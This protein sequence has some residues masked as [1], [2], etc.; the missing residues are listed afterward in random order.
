[1]DFQDFGLSLLTAH[2]SGEIDFGGKLHFKTCTSGE[3]DDRGLNWCLH[4]LEMWVYSACVMLRGQ[5]CKDACKLHQ[6]NVVL[7][8]AAVIRAAGL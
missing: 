8:K 7:H 2:K 6:I 1:M 3:L 5:K 4:I